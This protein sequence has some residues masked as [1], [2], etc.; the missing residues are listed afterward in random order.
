[1]V[2]CPRCGYENATSSLY[3]DNCAY[4][5]KSKSSYQ[6]TSSRKRKPWSVGIAKKIV[7]VLGIIIIAFLLFSFAFNNSQPSNNDT[8]NVIY[9]DGT[10]HQSSTYPFKAVI[11]S[12]GN[13][14]IK[15]GDPKYS[16]EKTG[17]GDNS[18]L[19][20]CAAWDDVEITAEKYSGENLTVQLLMNGKVVAENSTT[21]GH[22][23]VSIKYKN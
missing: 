7:I 21:N 23:G 15:M 14:Y 9:D 6:L 10:Q 8:L 20:D 19:L 1:M 17:S 5:L 4:P 2:R 11:K 22:S 12:D 18:F 13:W 16:V 3:C